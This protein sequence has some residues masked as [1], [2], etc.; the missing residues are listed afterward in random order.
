ATCALGGAAPATA[1]AICQDRSS[2]KLEQLLTTDLSDSEI[3]LGKLAARV[4]PMLALVTCA[5]PALALSTLLGGVDPLAL[6]GA[7]LI[8]VGLAVLGCA[9]ALTLSVWAAKPYEVMLATYGLYGIWLLAIPTWDFMG[10]NF[11]IP[12]SPDWAIPFIPFYLAIAP[13]AQPGKVHVF[14]YAGFFA[15]VLAISAMFIAIAIKH[16]RAVIA[17][18]A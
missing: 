7:F 8:T 13:Y 4:L 16:M 10:W 9:L 17:G 5:L 15:A 11:R 3:I 18:R 6:A 14:S 2:G 12:S 1:G